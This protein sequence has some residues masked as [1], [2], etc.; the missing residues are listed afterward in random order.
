[1]MTLRIKTK[2]GAITEMAVEELIE[3]DGKPYKS[4]DEYQELRDAVMHLEGRVSGLESASYERV[5]H[6]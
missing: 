3:V 1:M 4:A 6:G 5:S 2:S